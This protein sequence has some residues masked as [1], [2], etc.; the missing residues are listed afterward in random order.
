MCI[1]DSYWDGLLP[2]GSFAV[3][4]PG[5]SFLFG[6][7]GYTLPDNAIYLSSAPI[8]SNFSVQP[9][10]N[11][12]TRDGSRPFRITFDLDQDADLELLVVLDPLHAAEGVLL[13]KHT[14]LGF[15]RGV[16]LALLLGN[17]MVLAEDLRIEHYVELSIARLE[18]A[19]E[20]WTATQHPPT[21]EA[22][23]A[24]F[25]GYG[26]EESDYLAYG[27][28]NRKSIAAY[29]AAHPQAKQ[30]IE[31]LSACLLYTSDAADE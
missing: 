1:R 3:L 11:S 16:L 17:G 25:A 14:P 15:G 13:M 9:T 8:I 19:K 7:W 23:A 20:S 30:R 21:P 4:P 22:M 29:L 31:A 28:T 2:D 12:P 27:G 6:I 18:L 5:D 24:L 26:I 10:L